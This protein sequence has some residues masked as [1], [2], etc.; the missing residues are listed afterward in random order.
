MDERDL[1]VFI[2]G[3]A[4]Y[5]Q[6]VFDETAIVD[7]PFLQGKESV[8]K[9][10]TGVIGISG[11]QRGAIYFTATAAMVRE[12]LEALREDEI[13][14]AAEAD[15]VGEVANTISGNARKEFGG[16]FLISVPIVLRGAQAVAFPRNAQSF[17]IPFIWRQHRSCLI[18]CLGDASA[19]ASATGR[20]RVGT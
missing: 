8:I 5:F 7:P 3:V 14:E 11:R 15:I 16:D 17:V 19:V 9:D 2:K 10:Y 18:V 4:H 13:D 12:M 1:Q 6:Q 20:V